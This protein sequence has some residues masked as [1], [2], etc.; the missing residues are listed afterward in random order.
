ML[1]SKINRSKN[2]NTSKISYTA[3][4]LC[5]STQSQNILGS[6]N[7]YNLSILK[8]KQR[9]G[10]YWE[11]YRRSDSPTQVSLHI[12]TNLS[13]CGIHNLLAWCIRDSTGMVWMIAKLPMIHEKAA[14][15]HSTALPSVK[16]T[17]DLN[18][19]EL[20]TEIIK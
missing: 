1:F 18:S 9:S 20:F 19:F 3:L 11:K 8:R 6:W 4:T 12:H 17:N 16:V 13:G 5:Y 14:K 7:M 2:T 15:A 10:Q